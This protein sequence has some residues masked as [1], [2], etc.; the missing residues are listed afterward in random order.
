MAQL[1]QDYHRYLDLDT[2]ILVVGPED[3]EAFRQYWDA[4]DF[5]MLGMPDPEHKV[6]KLYGQEVNLF[7]AGR[8]PALVVIDKQGIIRFAHYGKQMSDIPDNEDILKQI[9]EFNQEI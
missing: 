2:E 4:Y 1:R 8:M 7:K 3:P 9:Q 5:E 6:L